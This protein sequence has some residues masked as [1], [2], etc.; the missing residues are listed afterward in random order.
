MTLNEKLN[1]IARTT[2]PFCPT[3]YAEDVAGFWT[4]FVEP[5][6]PPKEVV[7][8]WHNLLT[9]YV[10]GPD[11]VFVIR[12]FHNVDVAARRGF[13]TRTN[14]GYSFFY[15]DNSFA[16]YIAK[17]VYDGF[18]PDYTDFKNTMLSRKFPAGWFCSTEEKKIAAYPLEG[19]SNPRIAVSGYKLAHI[20]DSGNHFCINNSDWT[21]AKICEEYFP[22]GELDD[23]KI[24]ED[25]FGRFYV[26]NLDVPPEAK[27]I[28]TAHFLRYVDPLN[29]FLTPKAKNNGSTFHY[30]EIPIP[31]ND[32]AEYEMMQIFAMQKF[33][34]RF[35]NVYDDFLAK[36]KLCPKQECFKDFSKAG[37]SVIKI[38][39]GE[40]CV[41]HKTIE[42]S[43]TR[44]CFKA[45]LIEPLDMDDAFICSTPEGEFR[46]TKRQFYDVFENVVKTESYL[47]KR[48]YHYKKT[49]Q[50]AYQFLMGQGKMQNLA[51]KSDTNTR[52]GNGKTARIYT[53]KNSVDDIPKKY[54]PFIER[55]E[56]YIQKYQ[57]KN[58]KSK[59]SDIYKAGGITRQ[60]FSK[61]ISKRNDDFHPTKDTVIKLALG[62]KLTLNETEDLL[63]SS[64]YAFS[65]KNKTDVEIKNLL[66]IGDYN[67]LNWNDKIFSKT[68]ELFFKTVI[69]SEED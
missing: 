19:K 52:E 16:T 66:S 11:A 30:T 9:R 3:G 67:I 28:L 41:W 5:M 58:P 64:G 24:A 10:T 43:F 49:P 15:S 61:I 45:D 21:K 44:L 51:Y 12:G 48:I 69:E 22:A 26:R 31:K 46:M 53:A 62:L 65:E 8:A 25:A 40:N 18:V 14:Q 59:P 56:W 68:G 54:Q 33:S 6:L 50:K 37:S 17:M 55:L 60:T 2:L 13:L 20:V 47:V 1:S 39:Y 38:H 36:L 42:Y 35:G 27:D 32:I 57:K 63:Q 34:E 29:Y 7:L 4:Q 23:W